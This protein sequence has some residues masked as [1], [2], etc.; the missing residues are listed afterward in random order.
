MLACTHKGG[1]DAFK[2]NGWKIQRHGTFTN[3]FRLSK[4]FWDYHVLGLDLCVSYDDLC[5]TTHIGN[6]KRKMKSYFCPCLI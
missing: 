2:C 1:V 4:S 5:K 6:E 3:N